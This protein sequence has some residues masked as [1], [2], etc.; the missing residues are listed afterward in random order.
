MGQL[1]RGGS[2]FYL[3]YLL[4]LQPL[5]RGGADAPPSNMH[6]VN[7]I[8][9][10][11]PGTAS[12]SRTGIRPFEIVLGCRAALDASAIVAGK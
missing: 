1:G 8:T 9:R 3:S 12:G 7:D 11:S 5:R 10:T 6:M 4:A 2:D